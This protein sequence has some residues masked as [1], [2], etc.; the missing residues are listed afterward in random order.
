[1]GCCRLR[2]GTY[3]GSM[4]QLRGHMLLAV[5]VLFG[6]AIP[7]VPTGE[8][9][10]GAAA[11]AYHSRL[12]EWVI[13]FITWVCSVLGDTILLLEARFGAGLIRPRLERSKLAARVAQAEQDLNQNSF[14]AIV[15]GR[16]IPGG[17]TPVIAALGLSGFPMRRFLPASIVACGL[18]AGIYSSIGTI[19]GKVAHHPVWAIVVAI[20]FAVSIGLL[21]TQTRRLLHWRRTRRQVRTEVESEHDSG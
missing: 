4:D 14:I 16:L 9:V 19:G 1:L 8:M 21:I 17:R 11:V 10:S 7:F 20:S 12:D 6:S 2:S 18:W 15:T 3:G 5:W 13:F